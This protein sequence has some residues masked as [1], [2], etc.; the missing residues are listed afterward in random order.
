L[1]TQMNVA[2]STQNQSFFGAF[3]PVSG[4]AQGTI[5]LD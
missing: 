4:G 1:A 5:A 2:A 3:V